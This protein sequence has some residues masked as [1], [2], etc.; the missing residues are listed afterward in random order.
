M[1]LSFTGDLVEGDRHVVLELELV[2][3]KLGMA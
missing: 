3:R 1:L 2:V